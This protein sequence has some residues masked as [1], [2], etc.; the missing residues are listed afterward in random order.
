VKAGSKS[1]AAKLVKLA[2]KISNLRDIATAPPANWPLERR[3]KYFH[4]AKQVVDGLRGSNARLEAA[5]D[6][7]YERGLRSMKN[8]D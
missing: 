2:D 5:F 6:E 3:E 7:A 1:D 8:A 4:W